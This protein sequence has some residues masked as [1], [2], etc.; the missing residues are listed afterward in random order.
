MSLRLVDV[1]VFRA[2][3][4]RELA[5]LEQHGAHRCFRAGDHLLGQGEEPRV[6]YVLLRGKIRITYDDRHG[7]SRTL[8]ELGPGQVVGEIGVLSHLPRTASAVALEET[9]ALEL[10]AE[11]VAQTFLRHP[12][13]WSALLQL[14]GSR[15]RRTQKVA[16]RL[17]EQDG[18]Q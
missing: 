16:E 3:P 8:A 7:H 1:E 5:E 18:E 6:M 17:A 13:V 2:L 9:E 15:L 12:K 4:A 14:A 11:T 10:N